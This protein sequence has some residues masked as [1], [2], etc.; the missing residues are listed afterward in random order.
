M[1]LP[2]E[3]KPHPIPNNIFRKTLTDIEK[4]KEERRK[5][6]TEL[7]RKEYEEN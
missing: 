7:V 1:A 5:A 3:N 4:D 6:K 2:R